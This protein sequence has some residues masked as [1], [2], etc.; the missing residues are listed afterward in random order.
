MEQLAQEE[1][2]LFEKIAQEEAEAAYHNG[3]R[4]M[5]RCAKLLLLCKVDGLTCKQDVKAR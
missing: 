5:F 1:E 2:K 3:L 4:D